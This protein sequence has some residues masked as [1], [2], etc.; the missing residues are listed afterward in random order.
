MQTFDLYAEAWWLYIG[1]GLLLLVLIGY[2]IRTRSWTLKFSILSLLAVGAFTPGLVANANT[3]APLVLTSLL[4]AETEGSSA[5]ISG[6]IKLL[7]IWGIVL[8][9]GLAARHF[10][11]AKRRPTELSS[12]E[13]NQ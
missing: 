10:W 9:S 11:L 12:T 3:Y 5:I 8:T 13:Q 2:Q 4:N 1:L 7:V 6:L